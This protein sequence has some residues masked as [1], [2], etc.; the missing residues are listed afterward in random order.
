MR[1]K[2]CYVNQ[3][4]FTSVF[5]QVLQDNNRFSCISITT[6]TDA[7]LNNTQAEPHDTS[8]TAVPHTGLTGPQ[9]STSARAL[10]QGALYRQT[11]R[12]G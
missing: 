10:I 12:A 7:P 11:R 1:S 3:F 6:N 4:I 2:C 8:M 5:F 9:L